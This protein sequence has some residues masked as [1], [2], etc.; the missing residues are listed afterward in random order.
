M[1]LIPPFHLA[2]PVTN[3]DEAQAFYGGLLDCEQGRTSGTWID[4]NFFGHQLVT[5]LVDSMPSSPD[6]NEVDN[7][8][9]PV[10]HFGAVLAWNDW[11][12]LAERL[13]T[14]GVTFVIE[15]YIRF[16]GQPGEQATLFLRDPA[17]NALEFKA[18]QNPE[19]LFAR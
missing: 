7:N 16:K 6:D 1:K 19:R 12:D 10:P 11:H 9:V 13:K 18:F 8:K 17:G 2:I 15:P 5:H 14:A 4:W 3:L